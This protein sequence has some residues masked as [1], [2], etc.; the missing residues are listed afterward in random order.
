MKILFVSHDAEPAGAQLLL[1]QFLEWLKFTHSELSFE[2]LLGKKGFLQSRFEAVGKVW[3]APHLTRKNNGLKA[4]IHSTREE[5]FY[6]RLK[7]RQFDLIYLNTAVS[8]KHL[9]QLANWELPVITHILEMSFWFRQTGLNTKDLIKKHTTHFLAASQS[10]KEF[11][12]KENICD[13]DRVS[14][15]HGFLN[16]N[17]MF[18]DPN[19]SIHELLG[20]TSK[21]FLVGACG[22]EG[23]RKGKDWFIPVAIQVLKKIKTER[24]HFVWIGGETSWEIEFD[25]QRSG[26]RDRIHFLPNLEGASGYFHELSVFLLL[27]RE[28][29]FP[30][31]NLEA[32][33][34]KVPVL[35]FDQSG[36]TTELLAKGGGR[37]VPYGDINSMAESIVEYYNFPEL[38]KRDGEHLSEIV[39]LNY[40]LD[41]VCNSILNRIIEIKKQSN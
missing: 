19:K 25:L 10:V 17:K 14:I 28:D 32:G 41:V 4:L 31:V 36:G 35:G 23:F 16:L 38:R 34:S 12:I 5:L 21:S 29:P 27:S 9:Q 18:S 7:K 1:L 6:K 26:F 40:D 30:T 22:S 13:S 15:A 8:G 2:V 20:L 37:I 33:W 24:I 39:K 3:I 11:L